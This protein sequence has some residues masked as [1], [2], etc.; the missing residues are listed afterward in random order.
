M[1][2]FAN[3]EFQCNGSVKEPIR[4]TA[5]QKLVKRSKFSR[6]YMPKCV[7]I[8]FEKVIRPIHLSAEFARHWF[9]NILIYRCETLGSIVLPFNRKGEKKSSLS[10]ENNTEKKV[11][12]KWTVRIPNKR[13]RRKTACNLWRLLEKTRCDTKSLFVYVRLDVDC[14]RRILLLNLWNILIRY[15]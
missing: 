11:S 13:Y 2:K 3:K 14:Y 7:I 10:D 4:Y 9:V 5:W 1:N 6:N 15:G 8:D 12:V